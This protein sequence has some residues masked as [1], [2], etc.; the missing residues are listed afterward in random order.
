MLYREREI[1]KR[2]KQERETKNW[3]QDDLAE[4]LFSNRN[5]VIAWEH[6]KEE[7]RR[8][9]RLDTMLKMCEKFGCELG[10]LLCEHDGKTRAA[11]DLQAASKLDLNAVDVL[12]NGACNTGRN[13]LMLSKPVFNRLF[14][15]GLNSLIADCPNIVVLL[16][17]YVFGQDKLYQHNSITIGG[18]DIPFHAS[19]VALRAALMMEIQ[20]Q[21]D[22]YR[23]TVAGN[24]GVAPLD[25]VKRANEEIAARQAAYDK[26][27]PH[28]KKEG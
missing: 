9:P 10:Y 18:E 27:N 2:I 20:R 7:K 8:L 19:G 4:K 16:A 15:M 6:D 17:A 1:A 22:Q 12:V 25:G 11:T 14:R 28:K 3:T 21:L 5:S 23:L 13:T 24:G 26:H